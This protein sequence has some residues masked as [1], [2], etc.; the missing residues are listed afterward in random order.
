ME[1]FMMLL[2]APLF[3][4]LMA[5]TIAVVELFH[6]LAFVARDYEQPPKKNVHQP[7]SNQVFRWTFV[8]MP[9]KFI[10]SD[11]FKVFEPTKTNKPWYIFPW[12]FNHKLGVFTKMV[13][14]FVAILNGFIYGACS[15]PTIGYR[16]GKSLC[17]GSGS[18]EVDPHTD[19]DKL[20]LETGC[21]SKP[22]SRN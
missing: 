14:C 10:G 22:G 19:Q 11:W 12:M 20:F 17:S 6:A 1:I 13:L 4:C 2:L 21:F 8:S 3:V 18:K 15:G 7:I 16:F 5:P 9:M